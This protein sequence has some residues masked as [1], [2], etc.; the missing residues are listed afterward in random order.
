MKNFIEAYFILMYRTL[1]SYASS[2][3]TLQPVNVVHLQEILANEGLK[4]NRTILG[5]YL[6][7]KSIAYNEMVTVPRTAAPQF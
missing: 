7:Q 4:V 5:E 6:K 1:L 3:L 2:F